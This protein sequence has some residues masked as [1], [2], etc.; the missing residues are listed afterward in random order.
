M[1]DAQMVH[2]VTLSSGKIVLLREMKIKHQNL[3]SKAVGAKAADNNMLLASL[4]SQELLKILIVEIN[5]KQPTTSEIEDLDGLFTYGE[6]SQLQKV[7]GQLMGGDEGE[8]LT[9]IASIGKP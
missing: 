9:E 3:A 8:C 1:A 4:M 6:Y 2:K 5:G 7:V